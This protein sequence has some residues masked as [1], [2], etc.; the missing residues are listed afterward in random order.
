MVE[1]YNG[2]DYLTIEE[3]AEVT[4]A[5]VKLGYADQESMHLQSDNQQVQ[6]SVEQTMDS[7]RTNIELVK[8]SAPLP[9]N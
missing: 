1:K 3:S 4:N 8:T 5:A 9:F 6:K 2:R 7:G